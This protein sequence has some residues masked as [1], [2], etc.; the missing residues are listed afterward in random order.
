MSEK[1]LPQR[2]KIIIIGSGIVGCS[3]AYHLAQLGECD[4]VVLDKGD[5]HHNDGST[6][7]APG[8]IHVTSP[9]K[10]MT[11]FALYSTE[12]FASLEPFVE[13]EA[14]F[15]PVGGIEYASTLER[16]T[17]LKRRHGIAT[18]FGARAKIL[19]PEECQ[20]K[21]PILDPNSVLGG[22][23]VENDASVGG[24]HL[25]SALGRDAAAAGIQFFGETKVDTLLLDGSRVV[26]VNT[27]GGQIRADTVL[28]CTNIWAPILAEQV[29]LQLPLM[30]A[31]HQYAVTTP[32]PEMAEF[33][34]TEIVLPIM[35]DQEAA[36]YYRHHGDR[37]GIG[38]YRHE[39]LLVAAKDVG[40]TAMRDF[41]PHHF[42]QA[43][44]SSCRLFPALKD[45]KL[46]RSFNG[47][48]AFTLDGMPFMGPTHISGLWTG[49]GVWIT[50]SGGVGKAL[51]EWLVLGAPSTDCREGN[52]NRIHEFQTKPGYVHK[53][54]YKN[55][56]EVYDI[57]HPAEPLSEPRGIRHTPVHQRMLDLGAELVEAGGWEMPRW[58]HSNAHLVEEFR[59]Q[60][61][62]RDEWSARYWSPIQGA[63]HLA[64]RERAGLFNLG[65]LAVVEVKGAG[66]VDYLN[67]L[68]T[69]Q[70][71]KP[72]GRLIYTLMLNSRGG[73]RADLTVARWKDSY[74][75]MN[76]GAILPRELAWLRAH[77]PSDGSVQLVDKSS[78]L[79][80]LGLW[81][82]RA[83]DILSQICSD[84]LSNKTFPFY[85][86]QDIT[87]A[88][89]PVRALRLSYAGE[90]GWEL[91]T[92]AEFGL[93]LWDAIWAAGENFGL[94]PVG[95]GAFDSLR[96]EKAYR[97]WGPDMNTEH[98]PTEAGL[99]FVVAKKDFL[100]SQALASRTGTTELVCL[101]LKEAGAL[102]GG[103][104]IFCEGQ[105]VG[106]VTSAN[107]GYSLGRFLTLSRL[108]LE[109]P[110]SSE[111]D[112]EYLGARLP[113]EIVQ[114]PVFDPKME[115]L[116]A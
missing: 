15:R 116:K 105:K 14:C 35:R 32:V 102:L 83:R 76:G 65:A 2:A 88:D 70:M 74:W 5:L 86:C 50:H 41:T 47:M 81:G 34:N 24:S 114:D 92:R 9:S 12:V 67:R 107:Y 110:Q 11:D 23:W 55:Y 69:N 1:R 40:K 38:N 46:E 54:C 72:A 85:R 16:F 22:F 89:I 99:D 10:M 43:W 103:E 26:G 71:D 108:D 96:M 6:S 29:G 44:A 78:S 87:V 109:R 91:Y 106:Y 19:S 93:A 101:A 56:A 58:F 42:E 25:T 64:C 17:E 31:Q 82:P 27:A 48:F 111:F 13:G 33:K 52:V 100:G 60:I 97:L 94:V 45:T 4:V 62:E 95:S 63:E 113:A 98:T 115:R 3:V 59:T 39:P 18:A 37:W 51:A 68:C 61:P 7:H 57:H 77:L 66:A 73:V 53:R 21:V 79:T 90:L 49:V 36:T 75:I 30:A 84:D 80:T 112:V 8:G 20:E 104:P 28:V